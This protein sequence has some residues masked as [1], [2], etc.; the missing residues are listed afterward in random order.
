MKFIKS[1]EGGFPQV[2]INQFDAAKIS[3][4]WI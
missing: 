1:W 3:F 4:T 2:S